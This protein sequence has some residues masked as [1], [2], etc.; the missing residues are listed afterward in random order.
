MPPL[1]RLRPP[2]DACP[3]PTSLATTASLN[4]SPF[5]RAPGRGALGRRRTLTAPRARASAS[6]DPKSAFA[7][8]GPVHGLTEHQSGPSMMHAVTNVLGWG[9]TDLGA[10]RLAAGQDQISSGAVCSR[11]GPFFAQGLPSY[12]DPWTGERRVGSN[13]VHFGLAVRGTANEWC[14]LPMVNALPA[15]NVICL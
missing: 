15:I 8:V 13:G 2:G 10:K 11:P 4:L 3:A 12:A 5:R 14:I 7:P 9:P 1:L 6:G